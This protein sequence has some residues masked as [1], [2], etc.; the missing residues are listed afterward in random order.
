MSWTEEEIARVVA[1]LRFKFV[2]AG[3]STDLIGVHWFGN[4]NQKWGT[5]A[6]DAV[7]A[8]WHTRANA[9]VSTYFTKEGKP[10]PKQ[11]K[12]SFTGPHSR[13]MAYDCVVVYVDE[14]P[15]DPEWGEVCP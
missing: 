1:R 11:F 9:C 3:E 5:R 2:P 6:E 13:S 7:M 8:T 4:M 10:D 14:D 12:N 15:A